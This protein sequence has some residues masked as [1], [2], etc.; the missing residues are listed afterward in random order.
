MSI[1]LLFPETIIILDS[2]WSFKDKA[3]DDK[4]IIIAPFDERNFALLVVSAH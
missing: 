1:S 2:R 4:V 3:H